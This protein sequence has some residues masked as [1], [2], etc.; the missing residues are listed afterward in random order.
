VQK[1]R[2]KSQGVD[3]T[4]QETRVAKVTQ[5]CYRGAAHPCVTTWTLICRTLV[6]VSRQVSVQHGC[7]CNNYSAY[8]NNR[9]TTVSDTG[10]GVAQ[11]AVFL[12]T[13]F[14]LC[15]RERIFSLTSVSRPALRPTQ[16]S[17]SMGTGH[18]FPGGKVQLGHDADHSPDLVQRSR[19]S[20]CY[21]SSHPL[22][23]HGIMGQLYFY[24]TV[25]D[26]IL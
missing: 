18:S 19:M 14:E 23:L 11:S 3:N 7:T 17:Y 16:L 6:T 20:T 15:Q 21:S 8:N 25:S 10:A 24:F 4:V 5:S 26:T 22:H 2:G 9:I 12:M 1:S 13:G